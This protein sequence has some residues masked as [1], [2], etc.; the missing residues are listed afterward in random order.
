MRKALIHLNH[1]LIGSLL[2]EDMTVCDM[3][4]GNGYDTEFIAP[5]VN[6]VFAFDI[7]EKALT[8]TKHRLRD[9]NNITYI[10]DAYQNVKN[11]VSDAQLF[12]F[13]LGYLPN[14]DK[15]ITTTSKETIHTLNIIKDAYPHASIIIM[16]YIGH[17]E[18]KV[19]YEAIQT[20]LSHQQT[21]KV[22][23]SELKYYDEAPKLLWIYP[24]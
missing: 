23:Q 2:K 20:W 15:S 14:G 7:Q 22:I 9:L 6:H 17:D 16:S 4:C 11:Y 5:K 21:Y 19:E 13:N 10:H 8:S 24:K 1:A 3:T 18:G 12:M